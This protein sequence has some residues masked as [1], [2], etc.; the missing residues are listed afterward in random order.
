ML[1]RIILLSLFLSVNQ[2]ALA[3]S[4]LL[5][6]PLEADR[7]QKS[8]LTTS[9]KKSISTKKPMCQSKDKTNTQTK[10]AQ[11]FGVEKGLKKDTQY[12]LCD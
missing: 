10:P 5:T 4:P 8:M 9:A 7:A 11:S 2:I 1:H 6:P 3:T 12:Y